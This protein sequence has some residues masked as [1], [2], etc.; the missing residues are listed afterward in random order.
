MRRNSCF[1]ASLCLLAL[2]GISCSCATTVTESRRG[3]DDFRVTRGTLRKGTKEFTLRAVHVPGVCEKGPALDLAMLARIADVGGNTVA[4]DLCGFSPDGATLDPAAVETVTAY[5]G[6]CKDQGMSPLVRV[7]GGVTGDAKVR[8]RAA[9]A[10]AAALSGEARVVY[11][12]DG[13]DAANLAKKFKKAARGLTVAAPANGDI[14]VAE[15]MPEGKAPM[16]VLINGAY[17]KEGCPDTHFVVPHNDAIYPALDKAFTNPAELAPWTPDNSVLSEEERAE[18]FISLFDGKTLDGWWSRN[19]KVESFEVRDGNIE[20]V[21]GGAGALMTRDRYD[22]FILRVDWKIGYG[23]NSGIW[24]RAPREAR[25]SKI[26]FEYQMMGD[27]DLTE[28]TD[29]ST[30]SI[31][32][33]LPPL[34]IANKPEGEWNYSEMVLDGPHYKAYLNGVLVQDVNFDDDDEL[35]TRLRRGFI[36]L[37]DHACEVSFRNIRVKKL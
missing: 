25:S 8:E 3:K 21:R 13:P 14:L 5:A 27:S 31:Y 34:A 15:A 11:W 4:M 30:A 28:P 17:P 26:G 2:L 36:C 1:L 24:L 9:L 23:G 19:Q 32:S 18:G 29:T 16:P 35:R 6:R 20:W 10:A 33:V 7:L 37:T 12:I 22:N